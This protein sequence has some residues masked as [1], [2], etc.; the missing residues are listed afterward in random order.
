MLSK[1]Q[2]VNNC[3]HAVMIRFRHDDF[4]FQENQRPWFE[5]QPHSRT[6]LTLQY[7]STSNTNMP[8]VITFLSHVIYSAHKQSA[9]SR[10]NLNSTIDGVPCIQITYRSLI[11]EPNGLLTFMI[12]WLVALFFLL[13]G[14]T[15][16]VADKEDSSNR[17]WSIVGFIC[18]CIAIGFGIF[19]II[20]FMHVHKDR[21]SKAHADT[22]FN[23]FLCKSFGKNCHSMAC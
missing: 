2:F 17:A 21:H 5:L 14:P 9:E 12:L 1:I 20:A 3:N 13:L 8:K 10:F 6:F 4:I 16:L 19:F 18:L 11:T 22:D 7:I 15:I 23:Q